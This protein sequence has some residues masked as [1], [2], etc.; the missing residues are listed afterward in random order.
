SGIATRKLSNTFVVDAQVLK[1]S[2]RNRMREGQPLTNVASLPGDT[3]DVDMED[4]ERMFRTYAPGRDY[5]TAYDFARMH[6][7]DAVA[8]AR[9]GKGN[10]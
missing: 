7:G 3:A 5:L 4:F 8:N 10:M 1:V 9:A 2:L 6:E